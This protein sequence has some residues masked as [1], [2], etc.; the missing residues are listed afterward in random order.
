MEI[1]VTEYSEEDFCQLY[2]ILHEVYGSV[3]TKEQL[4]NHYLSDTEKIYIAKYDKKVVGC[5]F[6]Q[7]KEDYIREYK[8][9]FVSYVAVDMDYRKKGIGKGL[10]RQLLETTIAMGGSAIELTSADYRT[11]AHAFY[12]AIGFSKKKNISFH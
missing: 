6:L 4:E 3:I 5:A 12:N 7:I 10:F 2:R 11:D 1:I 8:Y 9:G